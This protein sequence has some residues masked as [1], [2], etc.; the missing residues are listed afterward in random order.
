M[1][2]EELNLG[3]VWEVP[4]FDRVIHVT[5]PTSEPVA[6]DGWKRDCDCHLVEPA[7]M[8]VEPG[9]TVAVRLRLNLTDHGVTSPGDR[10]VRI[11]LTPLIPGRANPGGPTWELRGRV[12]PY[13]GPV[14]DRRSV[15][16]EQAQPAPADVFAVRFRV[17]VR[18][19]SAR[20][21]GPAAHAWCE[22]AGAGEWRVTVEWPA[23]LP[24][25]EHDVQVTVRPIGP[26]GGSL[27]PVLV[28]IHLTIVPDVRCSPPTVICTLGSGS[29]WETEI[30]RVESLTGR[31]VG[32]LGIDD[33]APDPTVVAEVRDA[34]HVQVRVRKSP[35][36]GARQHQ[37]FVRVRCGGT[38]YRVPLSLV[39][40]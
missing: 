3:D 8:T 19:V 23:R 40:P 6:V 4:A 35:T 5:N 20:A 10:P 18:E 14:P 25:G 38:E 16:S 33:P 28:P 27:P 2:P 17:P 11:S 32:L 9:A 12:K 31:E 34:E 22:D 24:E 29:E 26:E 21:S 37:F 7:S 39:A 1:P 13:V 15:R 30:V 36:G